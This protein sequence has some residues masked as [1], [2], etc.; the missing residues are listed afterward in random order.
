MKLDTD[1]YLTADEAAAL[2][3]CG[4]RTLWRSIER[5]GRDEVTATVFGRL[6]VRRSKLPLI[7]KHYFKRGTDRAHQI[8]VASGSKGGKQKHLNAQTHGGESGN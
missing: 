3:G 1:N 5:A 6:L 4:K 7:E 8:A 2:I